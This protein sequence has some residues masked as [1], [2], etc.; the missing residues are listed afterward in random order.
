MVSG[1]ALAIEGLAE[2][3]RNLRSVSR[4]APKAI[5]RINKRSAEVLT[6]RVVAAYRQRYRQRTGRGARAIRAVATQSRAGIRIG[7]ARAPY[8][9]GQEFGSNRF[10]QFAP[11]SG[12]SPSGRGSAGR[13]L[14]PTIRSSADELRGIWFREFDREFA[15]P[16]PG[17][18]R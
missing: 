6:P 2:F 3:R 15:T 1:P 4:D 12:P 8:L 11:W 14:F 13:F 7:G 10:K 17:R 16:F 18:G 5:Q 9:I